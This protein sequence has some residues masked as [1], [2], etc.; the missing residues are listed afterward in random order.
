LNNATNNFVGAVSATGGDVT[1]VDGT[2]GLVLGNIAASGTLAATS[3]GGAITQDSSGSNAIVAAGVTTLNASQTLGGTTV[4]A[5]ITLGGAGNDFGSTVNATGAGVTLADG[6]GGLVLGNIAA[7]GTLAATS[8]GGAITQDSSG[9]NAIV[10]AGATTLDASQALGGA[11]VPASINLGGAGNDFGGVVTAAGKNVTLNDVNALT[12]GNVTAAGDLYAKASTNLVVNGVVKASTAD[13]AATS[14]NIT[15]GTNSTLTV[16]TGPTNFTAGGS[17]TLQGT[18]NFAGA[19]NKT[20]IDITPD[21]SVTSNVTEPRDVT[22][23][24]LANIP[25]TP[26]VGTSLSNTNLPQPLMVSATAQTLVTRDSS[27]SANSSTGSS[28]ESGISLEQRNA[29]AATGFSMMFAVSLPKGTSTMGAGFS[30]DLPESVRVA[31]SES[32]DIRATLPNGSELPA[33]LKFDVKTL[34]FDAGAVPDGSFPLQVVLTFGG[35]RTLVVISE[36]AD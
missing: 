18:N 33:W 13:L 24:L 8:T 19:V 12:L 4:P 32:S 14:G 36:R 30:F 35:E 15:Q 17:M 11:K 28:Q 31:A 10:A 1:L 2:G 26:M 29:P 7:S 20:G 3:T 34:R 22:S 5:N 21:V 23:E 6:T 9:S 27:S 25:T 16:A